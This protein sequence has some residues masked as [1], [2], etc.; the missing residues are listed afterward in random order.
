MEKVYPVARQGIDWVIES[1]ELDATGLDLTNAFGR[2]ALWRKLAYKQPFLCG[3]P[4]RPACYD[5]II[6][7]I[8]PMPICGT[9]SCAGTGCILGWTS[10]NPANIV[11]VNGSFERPSDQKTINIRSMQ[12]VVAHEVGHT[13]NLGDEYNQKNGLFK[14]DIN[15]PPASYWG[16]TGSSFAC[17]SFSCPASSAV[18]WHD[19]DVGTGST[20]LSLLDHPF[21]NTGIG[22]LPDRLSFMGS[23]GATLETYW[24]TPRIYDH[25]FNQLSPSA[26]RSVQA[27][28][29]NQEVLRAR[30]WIGQDDSL[31]LDPWVHFY[32]SPD[33]EVSGAYSI[34][35]LDALSQTLAS[36]G[37]DVSFEASD[38]PPVEIDPAPFRVAVPFPSGTTAFRIKHAENVIG[39]IPVSASRPAV[40]VISPNGGEVWPGSG[41]YPITW[42]GSDPDNDLIQYTVLYSPDGDRWITLAT[43][44]ET[45]TL[46]VNSALLPGGDLAKIQVIA[47][48]GVNTSQD[49]SDLPFTVGR[50]APQ[51]FILSPKP[52]AIY[53]PDASFYLEGYAYDLED[54]ALGE[55]AFQWESDQDGLLG[56]GRLLLVNLSP[57]SHLITMRA[58]D[59]DGNELTAS[60]VIQVEYQLFLPLTLR[61]N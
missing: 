40:S 35:A 23:G 43:D 42:D 36:Q 50:K 38:N 16:R 59:S 10:G 11:M 2:A 5:K 56:V 57:G 24:I 60:S 49:E 13:F 55:T 29:S 33:P 25:L 32:T 12:A 30:G 44:I 22:Q 26:H 61:S 37:F 45:T 39:V 21:D 28:Q 31:A 58:V 7:F 46:L 54:E 6:G 17:N 34:E 1:N 41:D 20:V 27:P 48:D 52:E 8:P 47:T 15:P 14:C 9:N 53:S 51:A 4:F 3:K 18:A 19:P